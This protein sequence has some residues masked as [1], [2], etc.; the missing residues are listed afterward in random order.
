MLIV[1]I[2]CFGRDAKST[3]AEK[4]SNVLSVISL[5]VSGICPLSNPTISEPLYKCDPIWGI[6]NPINRGL[7]YPVEHLLVL[8]S[9]N[10]VFENGTNW[11]YGRGC[12]EREGSCLNL[13]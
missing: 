2:V 3:K 8:H 7:P 9:I 1:V 11:A 13:H 12:C 4:W 10:V 6:G 5:L